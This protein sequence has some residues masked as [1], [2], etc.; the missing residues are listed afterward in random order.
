ME[1]ILEPK[2]FELFGPLDLLMGRRGRDS[3]EV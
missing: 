2:D 3:M 1:R